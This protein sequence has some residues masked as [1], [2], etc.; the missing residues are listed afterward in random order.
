MSDMNLKIRITADGGQ[1]KATVVGASGDLKQFGSQ[2]RAAG[3]AVNAGMSQARAGIQSISTQLHQMRQLF[4]GAFSLN[5]MAGMT[6]DIIDLAGQAQ[7]LDARLKLTTRSTEE[8]A[9]AKASLFQMAQALRA[10]LAETTDLYTRLAPAMQDLNRSQ[11]ETQGVTAAVA[12]AIKLSGASASSSAA[13]I[14]QFGQAMASGTLQGDEF[15][16]LMENAPRLAK[17]MADGLGVPRGELKKLAADGKLTAE[18]VINALLSQRDKLDS[19]FASLPVTVGDAMTQ[20]RN[21]WQR[22]IS[23]LDAETGATQA[24][25]SG[26]SYIAT[27][28]GNIGHAALSLTP[29]LAS[30]AAIKLLNVTRSSQLTGAL[31]AEYTQNL[32]NIT[33]TRSYANLM[34]STL[35][36]SVARVTAAHHAQAAAMTAAGQAGRFLQASMAFMAGPAGLLLTAGAIASWAISARDA[37]DGA[38]EWAVKLKG[39]N[40]QL[41]VERAKQLEAEITA[42][43]AAI[44]R[45]E[46]ELRSMPAIDEMGLNLG[47]LEMGWNADREKM[48]SALENAREYYQKLGEMRRKQEEEAAGAGAPGLG[49]DTRDIRLE[50]DRQRAAE[51]AKSYEQ[52][53]DATRTPLEKFEAAVANAKAVFEQHKDADLFGRSLA[54]AQGEFNAADPDLQRREAFEAQQIAQS[55]AQAQAYFSLQESLTSQNELME[56]KYMERGEIIRNALA[57][58]WIDEATAQQMMQELTLQHLAERGD[59]EAQAALARAEFDQ[60]DMASKASFMAGKLNEM[61]GTAGRHNRAMFEGQK[62][63]AISEGAMGLKKSIMDAWTWGNKFGGPV[64]GAS[65]ATIAA[66]AQLV[67]LNA[68][69]NSTFQGGGGG[70]G[71]QAVG[72]FPANPA[73]GLPERQQDAKPQQAMTIYVQGN[74]IDMTQLARELRPYSVELDRDRI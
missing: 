33:T 48:Q 40:D 16:S 73:T 59:I 63:A 62:A 9:T 65:M 57:Q 17:A 13:A 34:S 8:F 20:V 50:L 11:V 28:M 72:T 7:L 29:L 1:L 61:I 38:D 55:Q 22:T 24:L 4:V 2:G 74:L 51:L 10:P 30:L 60:Q 44:K 45:M 35:V 37:A 64:M 46:T 27:H 52:A 49:G 3:V 26:L 42:T 18:T 14:L 67:N 54:Q 19:E 69:R 71:T 6:R 43:T 5:V 21:E 47:G 70:A 31:A 58:Q 23:Q 32:L 25:A 68:I 12:Q 56:Q 39:L 36:P 15:K 41:G 66:G 53:F